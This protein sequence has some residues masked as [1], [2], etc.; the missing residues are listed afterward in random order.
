MMNLKY[1]EQYVELKTFFKYVHY[2]NFVFKEYFEH[3]D[4]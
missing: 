1:V 2:Y 4:Y 3:F